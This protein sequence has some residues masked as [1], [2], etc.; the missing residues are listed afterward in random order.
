MEG[1]TNK[2]YQFYFVILLSEETDLLPSIIIVP[3]TSSFKLLVFFFSAGCFRNQKINPD[4]LIAPFK[5]EQRISEG[6]KT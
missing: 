6:F 1:L 3:D 5:V 4:L 2:Y